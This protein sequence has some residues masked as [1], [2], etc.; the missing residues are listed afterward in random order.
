VRRLSALDD[1]PYAKRWLAT[2]PAW[3][4]IGAASSLK[5]LVFEPVVRQMQVSAC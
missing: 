3:Q 2:I 1:A 5:R 4:R